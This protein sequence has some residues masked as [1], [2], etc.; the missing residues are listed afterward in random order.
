MQAGP[1]KV[2]PEVIEGSLMLGSHALVLPRRAGA[3]VWSGGCAEQRATSAIA[4][5]RG[6]F[7]GTGDED[8]SPE[9]ESHERLHFVAADRRGCPGDGSAWLILACRAMS[10]PKSPPCDGAEFAVRIRLLR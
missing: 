6:Y 3:L 8:L 5:L 7:H 1:T 2:V 9:G 4:L 10:E